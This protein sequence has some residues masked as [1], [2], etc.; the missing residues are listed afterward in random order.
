M[1]YIYIFQENKIKKWQQVS[2]VWMFTYQVLPL[3]ACHG[4][5]KFRTKIWQRVMEDSWSSRLLWHL[6][7][8]TFIYQSLSNLWYSTF[9]PFN[10]FSFF[11]LTAS[12]SR[13]QGI[14]VKIMINSSLPPSHYRICK[15]WAMKGTGNRINQEHYCSLIKGNIQLPAVPLTR[16]RVT[17][18]FCG[19]LFR[20]PGPCTFWVDP[21]RRGGRG[22]RGRRMGDGCGDGLCLIS[23]LVIF[24]TFK[25]L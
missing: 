17:S 10:F 22:W 5:R 12:L 23:E 25:T 24:S 19:I 15:K 21:G 8:K 18:G 16:E 4:I 6:K 11:I 1:I 14:L 13:Y 7:S 9:Y 2:W 3:P 20:F